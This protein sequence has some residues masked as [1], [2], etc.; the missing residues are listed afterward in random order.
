MGNDILLLTMSDAQNKRKTN[1]RKRYVV[2]DNEQVYTAVYC[3]DP[4]L[5]CHIIQSN[6]S[7][8]TTNNAIIIVL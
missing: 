8:A 4:G 7:I 3:S 2:K 5:I 6:L 1:K